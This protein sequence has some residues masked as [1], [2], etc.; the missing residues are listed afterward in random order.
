MLD[1]R[2]AKWEQGKSWEW[3]GEGDNRDGM[4]ELGSGLVISG[5][6]HILYPFLANLPTWVHMDLCQLRS[7]LYEL[8]LS[9]G[10]G[11]E[12]PLTLR[13]LDTWKISLQDTVQLTLTLMLEN[14][15][16]TMVCTIHYCK[17]QT[18]S[19][20]CNWNCA[21]VNGIEMFLCLSGVPVLLSSL[22]LLK[23]PWIIHRNTH[24]F[25]SRYTNP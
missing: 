18:E 20:E 12:Y 13:K 4:G 22:D 25:R 6:P 17:T 5:T 15:W 11:D 14:L 3:V 23:P 8:D 2:G 7:S 16:R 21:D 1:C 19:N 9:L 10:N 24:A